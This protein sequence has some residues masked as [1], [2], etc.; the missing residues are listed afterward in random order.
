MRPAIR[1]MILALLAMTFVRS[2]AQYQ[3]S[4]ELSVDMG[5]FRMVET[6]KDRVRVEALDYHYYYPELPQGPALPVRSVSVLVPNG[7]ELVN[8]SY[9]LG[10]S[11]L[12]T[13]I[14]LDMLTL[15]VPVGFE[16]PDRQAGASFKASFP[17][18][19][20]SYSSTMVQRGYTWFS[21]TFSPFIY[22]GES[23]E[24]KM[25]K[26][27]NLDISYT[28]NENKVSVIRPERAVIKALKSR[29][30]NAE[31]LEAYYPE[32]ELYPE[33]D[34]SLRKATGK[35]VDYLIITS[36]ELYAA[37]RPLLDWKIRKGLNA[38]IV[39]LNE[40]SDQYKEA[41]I[42][43]SIKRYLYD[44][45]VNGGLKWVLMGGDHDVVPV[46][47]CYSYVLNG[48]T[49]VTDP[50]I[51]TDLY[52]A[53]FDK[54]FD[55]NALI[56][57][58]IGQ[59][60]QDDNDLVPEIYLSRVPLR[61][62]EQVRDFVNKTL[63]YE[64]H[65]PASG[66]S[67][68]MLLAGVKTW[69]LWSGKSDSHH[70]SELMYS[71][72][73][74]DFWDG[75]MVRLFDTG[76]DFYGDKDY[77][78]TAS[79]LSDQ[80]NSGFAFFH[81][82][83]H[84]DIHT[85]LMEEGSRF[86][87][88]D[89][90][91][92]SNTNAGVILSNACDVNA[93]DSIDPCLSEAFLRNPS[94]GGVAFFGSSRLGFGLPEISYTL[95]PSFQFNASFLDVLFSGSQESQWN[96]FAS[97][98]AVSKSEFA[99]TGSSGGTYLYLLYAINPMGDPELP[100]FTR[101]PSFFRDVRLY[102]L[103]NDLTVNTGGISDCRIC[104]SS[105]NLE[106][107]YQSV[108][109]NVSNHTFK[110]IPGAFQVTITAPNYQPYIFVGSPTGL[111]NELESHVRIYPNPVRENLNLDFNLF[112]GKIRLYDIQ[113]RFLEEKEIFNGSNSLSMAEYPP[114]AYLLYVLSE[115]RSAWFRVLRV[116]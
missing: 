53:C 115:N 41:S 116:Q 77:Q 109:E 69:T 55:W 16:A 7:A 21:F 97:V 57:D 54:R 6:G 85:F 98:A 43:L 79:N 34:F 59:V 67:E 26:K 11:V 25:V 63:Y 71:K 73:V 60:Y 104:V 76:T 87:V 108:V 32:K 81:Y 24:L 64:Q 35:P 100:L 86:D 66:F 51:P 62:V 14:A 3:S 33:N 89:A 80:L 49:E 28:L 30:L 19:V 56:D 15:P 68:R 46:Q 20:L 94:G 113:G 82:S 38:E 52:Y 48:S 110:D 106:E 12:E 75:N 10:D 2:K 92:L 29:M 31:D 61:T 70:R 90:F 91:N 17:D 95:G 42:Q 78:V 27:L 101:N 102:M 18:E 22:N 37:F 83:G 114:G 5:Q 112:T 88:D 45:Y 105:Q 44:R 74:S 111:K 107:G 47:G 13:N 93:F 4:V 8:F 40:I 65:Q 72:Y 84:G 23:G 96:S 103:G 99:Q 9:S 36:D 1:Y 39:T 50:S 58:K